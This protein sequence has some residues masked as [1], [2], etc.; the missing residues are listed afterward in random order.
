M[1]KLTLEGTLSASD[2]VTEQFLSQIYPSLANEI[3]PLIYVLAILYWALYGYK[4][5][6]GHEALSWNDVLAKVLMTTF[7]FAALEWNG[8]ASDIYYAFA[9]FMEGT[10]ATIMAGE[11]STSMLGALYNNVGRIASSLQSV[12]PYQLGVL[13]LGLGMFLLNC[14]LLAVAICYLTVAKLGLALTM[15]LLPIFL[16]FL[17][18]PVSRQWFMN[19]LSSMLNFTFIYILVI[20]IVRIGFVIFGDAVEEAAQAASGA[21][22]AMMTVPQVAQLYIF[23][24]VLIYF[25]LQVRSWAAGL[26]GGTLHAGGNAMRL[27]G[28]FLSTGRK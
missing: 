13:L 16:G 18:F 23:E 27:A 24:A 10:A 22:A 5:Y 9:S 6:A 14:L 8:I 21:D 2:A 15:L 28:G 4:I 20:T 25:M 19:W 17:L 1:A 26:T 11:S 12:N 3:N 7:V